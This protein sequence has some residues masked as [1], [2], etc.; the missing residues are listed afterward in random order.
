[1]YNAQR[2]PAGWGAPGWRP[3]NGKADISTMAI[4]PDSATGVT[5][6]GNEALW[7][8]PSR[9]TSFACDMACYWDALL[10]LEMTHFLICII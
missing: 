6:S 1:M 10:Y 4:P 5:S 3:V 7:A 2:Q 8:L 9:A